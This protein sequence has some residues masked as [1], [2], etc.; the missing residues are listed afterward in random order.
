VMSGAPLY[1][2][3][4]L[5]QLHEMGGYSGISSPDCWCFYPFKIARIAE[6]TFTVREPV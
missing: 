6:E 5:C 2:N 1:T 3:N 4:L